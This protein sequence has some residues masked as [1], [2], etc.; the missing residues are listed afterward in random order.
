MRDFLAGF[1]P[2]YNRGL[3]YLKF[4]G[5]LVLSLS[6]LFLFPG[7]S[8][9]EKQ[10]AAAPIKPVTA[11]EYRTSVLDFIGGSL[12]STIQ[13]VGDRFPEATENGVWN[14]NSGGWTGGYFAGMLWM[15]FSATGDSAWLA[16][17]GRYT[18]LLERF[19]TDVN[20]IDVGILFYPSFARGYRVTGDE[21]Y[22]EV[23]LAGARTMMRRFIPAGGYFQNWG[24]L[25]DPEQ[26]GFVII[27][28][29]I[30][31]DQIFWAFEQTG[32]SAF[33]RAAA[34]HAQRTRG[35]HVRDDASSHQ[36]VEFDP[37]TGEMLRGFHKQGY[38]DQSTWSRG[39]SW[40]IYGFTRAYG[41]TREPLFLETAVRMADWFI[42]RLPGDFVP[43]WDFQAPNI[44]DEARDSSAG[45]MAASALIE[46]AGYLENPRERERCLQA[47]RN[48]L[49]S[50][51][52]NYLTRDLPG[53]QDGVLTGG[54][55]FF[56]KGSSVDQ[57][58][59]WGD[60]YYL[61]AILRLL[62]IE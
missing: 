45:S 60:Y 44:P 31:L 30:N 5:P 55:Y 14:T 16:P 50:L 25:G 53:R 38:S 35:A 2:G 17:A 7:C 15:M 36:V 59:I 57:A 28:C 3:K 47:A 46:L 24:R 41:H 56:A 37:E 54:T 21:Y 20:N 61:E 51:T 48:I 6:T 22:R 12:Q 42:E 9:P 58:N 11:E 10:S 34:S 18:R 4:F 43:Y 19:K 27:D 26:D 13:A 49:D 23:G 39:Q 8:S 29:L 40:G 52:R 62:E 33:Y 1:F 32:D